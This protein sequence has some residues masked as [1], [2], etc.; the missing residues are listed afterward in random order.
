MHMVTRR[1]AYTLMSLI[2]DLSYVFE[3][4]R[5][6]AQ[7]TP[8]QPIQV[9]GENLIF[10]VLRR[11]YPVIEQLSSVYP[12]IAATR[13]SVRDW[14]AYLDKKYAERGVL[15][16]PPTHLGYSDAGRLAKDAQDWHSEILRAYAQQGTVLI[17]EETVEAILPREL[18]AKLDS[19]GRDDLD[20]GVNCILH[21]L[22]TPAAMVLL[23]VA[24]NIVRRYYAKI[25]GT[26]SDNA[27]WGEILKELEQTQ[28]TKKSLLGYLQYLKEKRNEAEHPGKRFSQEEAERILIHVK[29]LLE[30]VQTNL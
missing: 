1:V 27:R 20:D 29:G 9:K 13:D 23:R 22:P 24:E 7:L 10:E 11:I 14:I 8:S 15:F 25:S 5:S 6:I 18:V 19:I 12:N 2:W 30:E 26:P 16:G 21:L 28:Q 3:R 17:N 4:S